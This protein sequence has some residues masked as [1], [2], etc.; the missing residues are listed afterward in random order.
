MLISKLLSNLLSEEDSDTAKKAHSKGWVSGGWG[1][2]KDDS[3]K[4]VARTINGRLV[5]IDSIDDSDEKEDLDDFVD[6]IRN[7]YP[8]KHFNLYTNRHTKDII[9]DLIILDKSD[10]H[11]GVGSQI[12]M[13]LI[14]YADARQKRITLTPA[15]KDKHLGTTS[16]TRLQKFYSRFGFKKKCGKI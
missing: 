5:P 11:K 4:T 3:G 9:L 7:K 10:Q 12:M 14:N 6:L 15:L 1:T 8:V 13:D 2:W 16:K